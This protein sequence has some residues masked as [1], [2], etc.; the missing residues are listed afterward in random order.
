MSFDVN[1]VVLQ[2]E[3][4]VEIPFETTIKIK[5]ERLDPQYYGWTFLC[6]LNGI[7]YTLL[8][9]RHSDAGDYISA[10]LICTGDFENDNPEDLVPRWLPPKDRDLTPLII[11]DEVYEEV[12]NILRFLLYSSPVEMIAFHTRYQGKEREV[13]IGVLRFSHFLDMLEKRQILFNAVYMITSDERASRDW[14]FCEGSWDKICTVYPDDSVE[15][16]YEPPSDEEDDQ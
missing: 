7:L 12:V 5:I 9:D 4:A 8:K 15:V 13:I 1:V 16:H 6:S 3:K 10:F 11:L 14:R 2:Q